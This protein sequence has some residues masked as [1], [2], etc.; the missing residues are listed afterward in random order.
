MHRRGPPG[1]H[2]LAPP[3]RPSRPVPS[4][5]AGRVGSTALPEDPDQLPDGGWKPVS[6]DL[7]QEA[8]GPV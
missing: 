7:A 1:R 6:E 3:R 8:R 5:R 4:V 2:L